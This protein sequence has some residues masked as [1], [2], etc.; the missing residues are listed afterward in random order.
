MLCCSVLD[1]Y[2]IVLAAHLSRG[3]ICFVSRF[4]LDTDLIRH[5]IITIITIIMYVLLWPQLWPN[6]FLGG[7]A[8][9]GCVPVVCQHGPTHLSPEPG[10]SFLRVMRVSRA[11]APCAEEQYEQYVSAEQHIHLQWTVCSR[12]GVFDPCQA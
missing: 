12:T 2:G 5:I 7:W 9:E 11:R 6:L 1:H 4:R 10:C 3:H 8:M